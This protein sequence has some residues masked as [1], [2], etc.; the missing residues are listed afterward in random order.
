[1]A[2][3]FPL[4][5]NKRADDFDMSLAKAARNATSELKGRIVAAKKA[6]KK[7]AISA[8]RYSRLLKL[9]NCL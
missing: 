6:Q 3:I 8:M 1:M 4:E 2:S 9:S 7:S 5:A